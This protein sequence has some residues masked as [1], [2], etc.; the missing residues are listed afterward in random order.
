MRRGY[1]G[2][3]ILHNKSVVNVGT[4]WRSAK[5]LGADFIFTIGKRYEGQSTDTA[6][7]HKHIP[8]YSYS[9]WEHFKQNIPYGCHITAI[10]TG[11]NHVLLSEYSHR[12]SCIYLLGA[13]DEGIPD[14][15]LAECDDVVKLEGEFSFN[16][17]VAGSIVMYDRLTKLG[18][19]YTKML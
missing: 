4:L 12:Q 9:S 19:K 2:I 17:A 1:F 3:G 7:T 18:K 15:I 14:Y 11:E 5:I 8:L 6:F 10:E 13:E 16:V